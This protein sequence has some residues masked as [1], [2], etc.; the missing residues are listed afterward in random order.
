M[1][2]GLYLSSSGLL[3]GMHRLDVAANNL[4]NVNT[5]GFKPDFSDSLHRPTARVE[6]GLFN[7]ESSKLL[8]ALGGGALQAPAR[9]NFTPAAPVDTGNPLDVA[10]LGEGFFVV[11]S[12]KG[13]GEERL[14]LTRDGGFLVD[15]QGYLVT[16]EKGWRVLDEQD[17]PI[18][19]DPNQAVEIN[20]AGEIRQGGATVA[21]LQVATVGNVQSLHK[22]GA[23]MF[24]AKPGASIDRAAS[25][26]AVRAGALEA[27]GVDPIMAMMA[28]RKA[29]GAISDNTR[30][31]RMHDELMGRAINTF[32]RVG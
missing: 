22:V 2:Y 18:H 24:A 17:Q 15:H 14:R 28:V 6:D 30:M 5:T 32:A 7:L 26:S 16:G 11:D 12:G 10:I 3:T 29:S 1:N 9:T 21:Q 19:L 4:S 23:N 20:G 13:A 31:I 8:E 27:S 25:Q